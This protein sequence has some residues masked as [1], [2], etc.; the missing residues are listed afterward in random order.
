MIPA[1]IRPLPECKAFFSATLH[2]GARKR[3]EEAVEGDDCGAEKNALH[4]KKER[5]K[6][7]LKKALKESGEKSAQRESLTRALEESV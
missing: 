1:S 4:R 2:K 5:S 3:L 7:E 6:R